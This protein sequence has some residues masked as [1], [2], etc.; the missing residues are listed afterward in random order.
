MAVRKEITEQDNLGKG[1]PLE[2]ESQIAGSFCQEELW[3][4]LSEE[5]GATIVGGLT[6]DPA[7]DFLILKHFPEITPYTDTG[8]PVPPNP[9]LDPII[10]QPGVLL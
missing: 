5:E 3:R 4:E 8:V 7:L 1:L 2:P 10:P 6:G 9:Y